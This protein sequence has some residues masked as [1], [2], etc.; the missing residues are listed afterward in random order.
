[1]ISIVIKKFSELEN[2]NLID[3]LFRMFGGTGD[4]LE[5]TKISSVDKYF[6]ELKWAR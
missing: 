4:W 5:I 2:A 3:L 6:A 1:M